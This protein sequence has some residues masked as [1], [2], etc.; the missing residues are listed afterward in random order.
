MKKQCLLCE[1]SAIIK[2]GLRCRCGPPTIL[3]GKEFP[4]QPPVKTDGY[5]CQFRWSFSSLLWI[6][7][8]TKWKHR[9]VAIERPKTFNLLVKEHPRLGVLLIAEERETKRKFV[10]TLFGWV[11]ETDYE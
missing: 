10:R 2:G 11:P 6:T 7:L 4:E 9:K 8:S 1:K 5:C 3:A